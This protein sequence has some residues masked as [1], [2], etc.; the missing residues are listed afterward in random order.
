MTFDEALNENIGFGATTMGDVIGTSEPHMIQW[1]SRKGGP[2]TDLGKR[3]LAQLKKKGSG[4]VRRK[5]QTSGGDRISSGK[6]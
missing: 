4:M 2:E 1:S 3:R 5:I 6:I